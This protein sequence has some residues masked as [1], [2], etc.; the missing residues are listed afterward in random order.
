MAKKPPKTSKTEAEAVND[1][2]ERLLGDLAEHGQDLELGERLWAQLAAHG[3]EVIP[4]IL[5]YADGERPFKLVGRALQRILEATDPEL[6]GQAASL[7]EASLGRTIPL[8]RR[9]AAIKA[10]PYGFRQDPRTHD[11]LLTLALDPGEDPVA[12]AATLGALAEMKPRGPQAERLLAILE[13]DHEHWLAHSPLRDAVFLCLRRHALEI[14]S[15][16]LLRRLEPLLTHP[17]AHLRKRTIELIG[18]FGD[19][20]IIEH[21][22]ALPDAPLHRRE[23][24]DAVA[25]IANGPIN[26]LSMRSDAFEAFIARVLKRMDFDDVKVTRASGDDGIDAEC[27]RVGQSF[28]GTVKEK[29]VVQCKRYTTK[30]IDAATIEAFSRTVLQHQAHHGLF[31]T[32]SKYTSGALDFARPLKNLELIAGDDLVRRLDRDFSANR[33]TIRVHT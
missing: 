23:I 11:R 14:P 16:Q 13:T 33:Y 7:L 8:P 1:P 32:T 24:L 6:L 25:A 31:I 28:T 22:L 20:D 18:A 12:R 21:L 5:E 29:V 17:D 15:R 2:L 10:F 4:A 26:L 30:P 3:H 9:I 27:T 19:I